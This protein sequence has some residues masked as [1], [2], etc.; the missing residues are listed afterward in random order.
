MTWIHFGAYQSGQ[1]ST[2]DGSQLA[3]TGNVIMVTI[4]YRLNVFG[5]FSTG[6]IKGYYGLWDQI[7]A[8]RWVNEK[9]DSFGRTGNQSQFLEKMQ[10]VS[11]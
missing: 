7:L 4:Q 11:V 10:V 1:M 6:D 5:F 3:I 8:I 2:F 9:I